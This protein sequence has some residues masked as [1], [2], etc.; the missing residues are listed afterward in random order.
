MGRLR[1]AI[2]G[3]GSF[4]PQHA[5][6]ILAQSERVEMVA[7]CDRHP[8]RAAHLA[9]RFTAG[10]AA[11]YTD[12]RR[13][14]EEAGLDLLVITLPPYGH[15][16]E[17]ELAASRGIHL[18]IEKPIALTSDVAWQMVAA[19]EAAGIK[20]QVGFKFRFGAAV[21]AL[22]ERL[23]SGAAGAPGLFTARYFANALHAPWWRHREKSG[24][25]LVEQAI[26]LID[27]AR[28]FLGEAAAVYCRQENLFHREIPDYTSED[29]SATIITFK[30]KALALIA[31]TNGAIPG[32]WIAD[33]RLV[34][35]H[36]TADFT[37]ANQAVF[38]L[39]DGPS[40]ASLTIAE[41]RDLLQRQLLD[42]LEAIRTGGCTRTPL[43][44]GALSLDLALAAVRSAQAH[45][46][47]HLP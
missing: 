37:N 11:V 34:A 38:H 3:C 7:F 23:D 24:G 14:I 43:R 26:H 33:Y 29:V 28:Y 39:T 13:L 46:E 45:T 6:A 21:E 17:V 4:A 18:L 36:L 5:Q 27:L 35:Q 2:L 25:Q 47:V 32:R 22:K 9:D 10:A 12:H 42:L 19:A 41:D 44:E 20:T 16:D 40:P 15:T 31:A 30:N 8:E 1:A